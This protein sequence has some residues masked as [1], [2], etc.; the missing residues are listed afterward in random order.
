MDEFRIEISPDG[1]VNVYA[2]NGTF[3]DRAPKLAALLKTLSDNGIKFDSVGQVEQHRHDDP[4][5]RL[6]AASGLH[7]H[8]DGQYHQH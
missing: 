7:T 2:D 1:T 5:D 3:Q 6:L 8:G 4:R